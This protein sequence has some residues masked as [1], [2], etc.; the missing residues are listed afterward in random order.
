MKK[1]LQNLRFRRLKLKYACLTGLAAIFLLFSIPGNAYASEQNDTINLSLRNASLKE[2][3]WEIEKRTDFV[4]AY[5]AE[6]ITQIQ[7]LNVDINSKSIAET[8]EICLQGTGLTY[9]VEQN[10]IVLKKAELPQSQEEKKTITGKVLDSQN[11]P[12]PGVT[13]RLKGTNIGVYTNQDGEF[14]LKANLP[15]DAVLLFTFIGMESAEVAVEGRTSLTVTMKEDAQDVSEVVVTGAFTR[16]ANTYTGAVTTVKRDELLKM[17]T[18]NVLSGLAN[19]DP[20]FVKVDNLA[21]GS[22]PNAV[23]NYQMRGTSSIS[24]NFQSQYENDPNQP[25]FILDGFETS[26]EKIKDLDINM[27]ES[28]TLLKDATAKAIYGSKGA[29]GVVVVE[30]RRPEGGKL[31]VTYNGGVSLEM[32]D[33][34]SY[35]LANAGEK[36]EIERMA[37]LYESDSYEDQLGLDQVYNNKMLDVL[38]GVDTDWMAQPVR[39]GVGQKHS[40]YIDGGD[41]VLLY[42]VDL[43]YNNVQGALKGSDRETFSG[44][45]TLTYR[46]KNL[47]IRN[48]LAV[49]NNESNNSPYGEYSQ[50]ALMNPYSRIHDEDGEVVQSY[51]YNGTDEPNPIWNTTINTTDRLTYTDITNNFYGEWTVSQ[52]LKVIGR[53]GISAKDTKSDVFKPASHTDFIGY[54]DVLRKGSY[55]Q[56]NGKSNYMNG[57]LGV[58]YSFVK[59]K[60]LVFMNGQANFAG[61][62]YDRVVVAAEGFPNDQMDHIIFGAQYA[63]GGKPTGAEGISHSAGGLLSTNYSYDER[64]LFDAN[65]RLTGSSEYGENKRWGSFWSVGAGWNMHKEAFLVGNPVISLLKL[66]FSMGY[67]GSQGFNTYEALSTVRYYE[68][69]VYNGNIGSYL[70]SLANPDLRW[71]SKYDKSLGLDF[72]LLKN[73]ISGRFDY[74]VANTEDM[75]TDVTLPPSTGFGY[76]R[77][78]LGKT[79]NKG[80]E[81]NLNVRAYQGKSGRDYLNFYASV[82][83]NKNKLKE[84]SNSLKAFNDSQDTAKEGEEIDD[85]F[86]NI[87]TPSVRFV[88]GQSINTIWAV[89]SLGIDP[90]S[91]QEIFVKKDGTTTYIWDADDQIA[92][93]DAMPSVTGNIGISSEFSNIGCNIS[94]Y[95]RLGGQIYNSTLVNKVENADVTYNVDRRVFTDRW[96]AEGDVARFKSIADK[97][98]TRPTTRFVEDYNTLTL[99]SVNFY[100]DFRDT[101]LV[102]NSFLQQLR[103]NVNLNDLFVISSVKTERGTSYPFARNATFTIQATF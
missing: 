18:Q 100:Y 79:Q 86:S 95:Y 45:I 15:A 6:D 17:S 75:L 10:V 94:F 69:S 88:E 57:D 31:R 62:S 80:V 13:V 58:S 33:L 47:L 89:Q 61:N 32:P 23:P 84:I 63:D 82:A 73:R 64:Y 3:L 46:K 97:S 43:F 93:G 30:S 56:T 20:S 11:L 8:L 25:L 19:I 41:D 26:I 90:Q 60:H 21:A 38:R 49:T 48:R 78:N 24:Q 81:A 71:Q 66:R 55:R 99:S 42:G 65:Y 4:F 39:T 50:Y 22:D 96:Q 87:T 68:N 27:I 53:L 40:V 72:A 28:I 16:K 14:S 44:G 12:M 2:V 102:K 103:M 1:Q 98:Y 5:N 67:T 54:T 74:Y 76:Y 52:G 85:N 37:G 36:L 59:G 51:N 70:V 7:N 92:A 29:N 91:G 77:A 34:S 9:V 35:D 83:H 101:R